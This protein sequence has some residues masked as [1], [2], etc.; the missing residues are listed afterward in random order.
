MAILEKNRTMTVGSYDNST[1]PA[2]LS[3]G[4]RT[5]P[6]NWHGFKQSSCDNPT[7]TAPWPCGRLAMC[8]CLSQLVSLSLAIFFFFHVWSAISIKIRCCTCLVH[9]CPKIHDNRIYPPY[10][11]RTTSVRKPHRWR[12]I[13][14][15]YRWAAAE[16]ERWPCDLRAVS[17]RF[18]T[19]LL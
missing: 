10:D 15:R 14:V 18:S 2:R 17:L 1:A 16:T 3:Q 12:A 5:V 7:E 6:V 8:Q 19:G 11:L 9:E 4:C 13:S